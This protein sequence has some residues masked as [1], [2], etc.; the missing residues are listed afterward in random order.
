MEEEK[1]NKIVD[2]TDRIAV[3]KEVLKDEGER[4]RWAE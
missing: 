3:K 4:E 2:E 1:G